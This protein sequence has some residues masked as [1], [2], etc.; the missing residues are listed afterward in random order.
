MTI[1]SGAISIT[2]HPTRRQPRATPVG[3]RLVRTHESSFGT[4]TGRSVSRWRRWRTVHPD[5]QPADERTALEQRLDAYRA[6]VAEQLGRLTDE[7]ARARPL[8]A[9]DMTAGGIVK[10]LAWAEDLW[11]QARFLGF[12]LPEPWASAPLAHDDDWPF[13]SAADDTVEDLIALH[14]SACDRSRSA[15]TGTDLSATAA[16]SS[17]GSGP[18][19][20]RWILVHMIDETARHVGH[21]DLLLDALLRER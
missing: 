5:L 12:D 15:A 18:V 20:L 4:P 9:T 16:V 8:A 21:L 2:R 13:H 14:R 10:H 3:Y 19:S 1:T 11:F 7:Q 17:F 6:E